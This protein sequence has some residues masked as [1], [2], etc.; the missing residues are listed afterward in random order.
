MKVRGNQTFMSCGRFFYSNPLHPVS[1]ACFLDVGYSLQCFGFTSWMRQMYS[2]LLGSFRNQ[3]HLSTSSPVI[4]LIHAWYL[5]CGL[6]VEETTTHARMS[7]LP[8]FLQSSI[9]SGWRGVQY[10]SRRFKQQSPHCLHLNF[11]GGTSLSSLCHVLWKMNSP[12]G[13]SVRFSLVHP[14]CGEWF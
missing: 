6:F 4:G 13:Q 2:F 9:S 14:R 10:A 12:A 7:C 11:F 1:S 8:S 3:G 5:S